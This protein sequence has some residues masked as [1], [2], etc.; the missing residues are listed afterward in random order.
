MRKNLLI[1]IGIL[2]LGQLGFSLDCIYRGYKIENNE[3]H[4]LNGNSYIKLENADYKTFEVVDSVNYS[5]LGKDKDHVYYQGKLLPN[6]NEKTFKILEEI[7][8]P[9]QKVWG[10]GCG[11]S[12]YIIEDGEQRYILEEKW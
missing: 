5:I 3:V 7:T 10:Y 12:G 11:A 4:Y 1:I 2:I 6:I 9:V 8:P